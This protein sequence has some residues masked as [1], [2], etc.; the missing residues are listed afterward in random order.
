MYTANYMYF[1]REYMYTVLSVLAQLSITRRG[2]E[3]CNA[4][5]LERFVPLGCCPRMNLPQC[6]QLLYVTFLIILDVVRDFLAV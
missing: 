3:S 5:L 2:E 1:V 6:E 4:C